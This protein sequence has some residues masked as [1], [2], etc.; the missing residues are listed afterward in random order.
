MISLDKKTVFIHIPRTAGTSIEILLEDS[1]TICKRN[2]AQGFNAPLNHLTVSQLAEGCFIPESDM[3]SYFKFTFIRNS[4]DRVISECFCPY[5]SHIFK[6]CRDIAER[7]ELGCSLAETG[8][9]G[10]FLKQISFIDDLTFE[11]DFIGRYE[12]LTQDF[13]Y[14]SQRIKQPHLKL[15]T[16]TNRLREGYQEYYNSYTRNLVAHAFGEEIERFKYF[17]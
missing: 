4:W 1:S 15:E 3:F 5:I 11:V 2:Q 9:G 8:Y 6:D 13:N 17:F 16:H 7:I 12:N 14:I 10:H